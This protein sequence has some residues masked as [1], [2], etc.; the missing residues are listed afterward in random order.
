MDGEVGEEEAET[1]ALEEEED[2]N[3]HKA[4][5]ELYFHAANFEA[6]DYWILDDGR[7][8]YEILS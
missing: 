1:K 7:G 2:T 6:T 4:R 3:R 5:L 8:L